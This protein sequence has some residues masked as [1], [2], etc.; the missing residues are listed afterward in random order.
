MKRIFKISESSVQ[1][2][3]VLLEKAFAIAV[4][5]VKFYKYLLNKDKNFKS[6]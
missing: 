6:L 1:Y 4:R 3:N 5:I 2:G